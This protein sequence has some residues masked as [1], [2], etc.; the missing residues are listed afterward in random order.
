MKTEI[1]MNWKSFSLGFVA[2]VALLSA[3][4]HWRTRPQDVTATWPDDDNKKGM[5]MLA[6]WVTKARSWKLGPF[7]VF[8]PSDPSQK[9]EA[10]MYPVRTKFPKISVS[11]S[12]LGAEPSISFLDSKNRIISVSYNESTGEFKS[13][14]F[15]SNLLSGISFID[16]N[17]DGQY[18]VRV[19][20]G[21]NIAI[22]YNS[23]WFPLILKD[24]K[25]YIE[26]DGI[27]KEIEMKD[28]VWK[29]A[30]Q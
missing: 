24:K 3:I 1:K 9:A 10:M 7:A 13:Y 8:A 16:G 25:K 30:G 20:P 27:S 22:N 23:R 12:E 4:S 14:Y 6:P 18:D 28:F 26:I 29:F 5:K 15:S 19:G 11:I 17:L 21:K 2:G